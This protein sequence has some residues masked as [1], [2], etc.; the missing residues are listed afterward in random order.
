MSVLLVAL[1]L[2]SQTWKLQ[3]SGTTNALRHVHFVNTST[4]WVVG[5]SGTILKTT[6]GGTTW[7]KIPFSSAFATL[8]GCYFINETT[9]WVGGDVGVYKTTDGGA[10]WTPQSGP[11]GIT[12]LFFVDANL[13]W[14]VGGADG[15]TPYYGDI[16]KTVD[17]GSNWTKITNN[18]TWARF[19]G[20]Q[21]I[22]A[23]TG[24]A[25]AEINGLLVGTTDGGATWQTFL[26]NSPNLIRG[27][28]FR[29]NNTGWFCGRSNTSG[30]SM[31]TSNGGA[32][33]S[34]IGGQLSFSLSSIQMVSSLIGWATSGPAV[35]KTLDGGV[36]WTSDY[37]GT[38]SLGSSSM[39]FVDA[40]HGWAVGE[41]GVILGY[42]NNSNE[43]P[44]IHSK[45]SILSLNSNLIA[46]NV[47]ID[48]VL[49][50]TCH[51]TLGVYDVSGRQV[52]GLVSTEKTE[53]RHSVELDAAELTAG[54]YFVKI[55]AGTLT[56]T[57]KFVKVN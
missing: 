1:N 19:Y 15:T 11:S 48:F 57:A 47:K 46:G 31:K 52:A 44:E 7:T 41:G 18:T 6:N 26:N 27:I 49:P 9:G 50:K 56:E 40:N 51:V 37:L 2:S 55:N 16:Y 24:W 33:W 20:V 30:L 29:D 42:V 17:G 8:I 12:K 39:C 22:N 14:A 43:V 5:H 13:G 21:F 10:T 3:T 54:V 32:G 36:T 34:N 23:T 4:G 38:T 53:G 28:C 25:Y 45:N 35:M